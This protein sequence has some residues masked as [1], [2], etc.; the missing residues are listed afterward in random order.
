MQKDF[1]DPN[2]F[3]FVDCMKI[4]KAKHAKT[5]RVETKDSL[6]ILQYNLFFGKLNTDTD[7]ILFDRVVAMCNQISTINADIVCFQEVIPARY[8]IITELLNEK[9][10][11]RIPRFIGQ[12]YDVAILSKYPMENR[13]R[14]RFC[15]TKMG[16]S[17]LTATINAL[18]KK[19]VIAT[20][21]FESEFS[22]VYRE[23]QKKLNQYAECEKILIDRCSGLNADGIIFAAD[24]NAHNTMSDV[25]LYNA[26]CYEEKLKRQQCKTWKDAWIECGC[27]PSSEFTYD[28]INNPIMK[29]RYQ[30]KKNPGFESR[31]DRVFHCTDLCV[32]KF[33]MIKSTELLSDHFPI[34]V[35]FRTELTDQKSNR[36]YVPY[37]PP[38]VRKISVSRSGSKFKGLPLLKTTS[39]SA[40]TSISTSTSNSN[41]IQPRLNDNLPQ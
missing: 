7:T 13:E 40:P 17:V 6:T 8:H 23:Q 28:S 39:A 19:L 22:E 33:E 34:A 18:G 29:K 25:H 4:D 1:Y 36:C 9:Y 10:P 2:N 38:E 24:F 27:N 26:F 32:S 3:G 37:K 14:F 16:R 30:N 35:T 21:H 20:S 15:A 5:K 11:Y 12:K 41:T 31:L